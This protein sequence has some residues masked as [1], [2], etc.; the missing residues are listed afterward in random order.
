MLAFAAAADADFVVVRGELSF[1]SK[2]VG[3][4]SECESGRIITLGVMPTNQYERL[5]QQYWRLS[6]QGKTPVLIKVRGDVTRA[7]NPQGELTLESPNVV[8]L[9]GGRCSDVSAS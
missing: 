5:V 3:K 4:I 9:V 6:Y 1:S 2:G 8:V 7:D